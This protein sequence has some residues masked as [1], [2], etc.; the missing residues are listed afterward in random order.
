MHA[1]ISGCLG[2]VRPYCGITDLTLPHQFSVVAAGVRRQRIDITGLLSRQQQFRTI[3]Q[4]CHD[5]RGA[6]VEVPAGIRRAVGAAIEAGG[7]PGVVR[8][9][10]KAPGELAGI[11]VQCDDGIRGVRCGV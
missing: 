2:K 11:H 8:Q 6:E 3:R 7:V 9:G 4:L 5:D 10:L 1:A